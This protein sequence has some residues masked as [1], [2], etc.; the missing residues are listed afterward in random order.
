MNGHAQAGD[1]PIGPDREVDKSGT[2][3][4]GPDRHTDVVIDNSGV[5]DLDLTKRQID[6]GMF[7]A[8]SPKPLRVRGRGIGGIR[9]IT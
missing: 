9:N 8:E 4:I 2:E 1:L 5:K 7:G 3:I 6:G